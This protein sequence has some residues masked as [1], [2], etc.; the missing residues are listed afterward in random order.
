MFDLKSCVPCQYRK[1]PSEFSDFSENVK[2]YYGYVK[3]KNPQKIYDF[4]S[5]L[6]VK[7]VNPD[8]GVIYGCRLHECIQVKKQIQLPAADIVLLGILFEECLSRQTEDKI[9]GEY[10]SR[11]AEAPQGCYPYTDQDVKSRLKAL[12]R[13]GVIRLCTDGYLEI[14]EE[15]YREYGF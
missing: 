14:C 5:N 3:L 15:D 6:V 9:L 1:I 10:Q 11:R 7:D 4:N 13:L 2:K 8:H 12:E